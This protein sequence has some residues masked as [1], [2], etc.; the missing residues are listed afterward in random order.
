MS[1]TA[2]QKAVER[3]VASEPGWSA[4][5]QKP[6]V[7]ARPGTVSTGRPA[8]S[9]A[10]TALEF[11]E[12]DYAQREFFAE[13][14]VTSS[15]GIFEIAWRPTRAIHGAAGQRIELKEPPA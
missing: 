8:S 1:S 12:Q 7:G 11:V 15:D 10:S 6:P 5:E 3:L 13:R 4:F 14:T 9:Q 2:L